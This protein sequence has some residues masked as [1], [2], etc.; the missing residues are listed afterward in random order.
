MGWF[1]K[2]EPEA[3]RPSHRAAGGIS[4]AALLDEQTVLV[5]PPAKDKSALLREL[6]ERACARHNLGQPESFVKK[7]LEREEGIS[8]TLDTGL[9]LPHARM[10][11]VPGFVAAMAVLSRGVPDPKQ[12]DLMIRVMFLFF[13]PNRQEAFVQHLHLLRAVSSLFQAELI[14]SLT[15]AGSAAAALELVRAAEGAQ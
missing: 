11:N 6:V 7:V 4:V 3:P 12:N 10:D 5:N 14:E 15:R 9:S 8:T 13:S 2:T 1:K